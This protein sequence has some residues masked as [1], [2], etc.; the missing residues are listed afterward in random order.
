MHSCTSHILY[1]E[2]HMHSCIP[3]IL[4]NTYPS[5][6]SSSTCSY[7]EL[8]STFGHGYPIHSCALIMSGR[9]KPLCWWWQL[10]F[11][12]RTGLVYF[13]STSYP[14]LIKTKCWFG[15][16]L[17]LELSTIQFEHIIQFTL[18]WYKTS[19]LK[20]AISQLHWGKSGFALYL[21]WLGCTESQV[22][23]RN[24]VGF[25]GQLTGTQY[26][27]KVVMTA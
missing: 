22:S 24:P 21:V 10:W 23:V 17:R 26:I 7:S 18:Y 19:Q 6:S 16:L 20:F 5:L 27:D 15:E 14:G 25:A 11:S 4:H 3:H 1:S 12:L 9:L 8:I 13:S 2:S